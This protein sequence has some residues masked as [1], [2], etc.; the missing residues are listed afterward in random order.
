M[1]SKKLPRKFFDRPTI[2]VAQEL[3]GKTLVYNNHRGRITETEAYLGLDDPASHAARGL[4]PRTRP[5]F[6]KPG[7]S[8]IYFIYGMYFCL[9]IV[10]EEEG[11][12]AA[13]LIRG[14]LY[15][16]G[17]HYNGP[18]KLCRALGLTKEQN[19]ID[20][21]K[22]TELYVLDTPSWTDFSATPRIGIKQGLDKHWRF[23]ISKEVLQHEKTSVNSL[24]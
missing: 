17:T 4:T 23:L 9:N 13:V 14:L 5:M 11:F 8:Y 20:M 24:S 16:D 12:P 18:G 2:T 22:S 21:V 19:E 7:F 10:T 1:P 3:L 6:G 15:E